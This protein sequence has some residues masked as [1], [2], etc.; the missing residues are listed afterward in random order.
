MGRKKK[1]F[2]SVVSDPKQQLRLLF[3]K[4]VPNQVKSEIITNSHPKVV[5]AIKNMALDVLRGKVPLT[6]KELRSLNP[7]RKQLRKL[8]TLHGSITD[9]RRTLAKKNQK[10][11][12]P[13]L[14]ALIPAIAVIV[15]A[16]KIAAPIAAATAGIAGTATGIKTLVK[17]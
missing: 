1:R 6:A 3:E 16:A 9:M 10:G 14:A 13:F 17:K 8:G 15:S 4:S 11:G 7:H 12:L 5:K 2:T